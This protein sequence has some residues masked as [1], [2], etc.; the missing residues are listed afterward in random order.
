MWK[1]IIIADTWLM[2]TV[3][4]IGKSSLNAEAEEG[5]LIPNCK[6]VHTCFMR[7]AIDVIFLDKD[8][9]VVKIVSQLKP[10]RLAFGGENAQHTLELASETI[11]RKSVNIGDVI[12]AQ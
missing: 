10:F 3:G 7:F 12:C 6:A 8:Y 11:N 9:R 2:R 1:N 4:L 5:L